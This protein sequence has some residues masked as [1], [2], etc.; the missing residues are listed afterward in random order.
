MKLSRTILNEAILDSMPGLAYIYTKEG[1]L[2]A[3]NKRCEEILGYSSEELNNRLLLDFVHA[4]D[5]ERVQ[6]EVQKVFECGFAQVEH[7]ILT[8]EGKPIHFLGTGQLAQ[9]EGEEYLIGLA[10]D[11]TE[12]VSAREKIKESGDR[13]KQVE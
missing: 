12:L 6:K 3:W 10:M 13:N 5:K 9:I 4:E 7:R 8:R 1:R 2:V 11:T